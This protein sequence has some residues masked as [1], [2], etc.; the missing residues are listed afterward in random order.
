MFGYFPTTLFVTLLP[1]SNSVMYPVITV[2]SS[3]AGNLLRGTQVL[4]SAAP[5]SICPAWM[6]LLMAFTTA[7]A[8]LVLG[9]PV[10]LLPIGPEGL[11]VSGS[12]KVMRKSSGMS[13]LHGGLYSFEFQ[14][15]KWDIGHWTSA[16]F[17]KWQDT[18]Q[19]PH[20]PS[21]CN[22]VWGSFRLIEMGFLTEKWRSLVAKKCTAHSLFSSDLIQKC[23]NVSRSYD[24]PKYQ[25]SKALRC[26]GRT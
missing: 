4:L 3:N 2:Q 16:K 26:R 5:T 12:L 24:L 23:L 11:S 1:L 14:R 17:S 6:A 18:H 25:T 7:T 8:M 15:A 20:S 9:S 13:R 19:S 21:Y 10:H 22:Q